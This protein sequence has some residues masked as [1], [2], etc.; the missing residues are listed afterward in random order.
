MFDCHVYFYQ[1]IYYELISLISTVYDQLA[2]LYI[3]RLRWEY[4][5]IDIN[6]LYILTR[7]GARWPSGTVPDLRSRG[8]GFES[9]Q[10]LL[11]INA[12]SAC[13]PSGVG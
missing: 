13:H 9:H 11:C 5:D 6:V 10:Q 8:R 2:H 12:N 1:S 7:Y 4:C 3:A